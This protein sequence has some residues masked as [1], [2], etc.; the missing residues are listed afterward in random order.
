M[1][2]MCIGK[3][4]KINGKLQIVKITKKI[5][6]YENRVYIVAICR[7]HIYRF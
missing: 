4:E 2:E 1:N 7:K 6:Q 5:A 3:Q